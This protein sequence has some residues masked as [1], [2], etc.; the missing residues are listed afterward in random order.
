MF[1]SAKSMEVSDFVPL[2]DAEAEEVS[3]VN[4]RRIELGSLP[5]TQPTMKIA[6]AAAI[7]GS[8]LEAF[9]TPSFGGFELCATSSMDFSIG[10]AAGVPHSGQKLESPMSFPQLEQYMSF[11]SFCWILKIFCTISSTEFA[12]AGLKT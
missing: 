6:A 5:S 12:V 8:R 11:P 4:I 2:S 9:E 1:D 10:R 7:K 3:L